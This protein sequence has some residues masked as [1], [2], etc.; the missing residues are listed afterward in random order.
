M[1]STVWKPFCRPLF[2]PRVRNGDDCT[3]APERCQ[4]AVSLLGCVSARRLGL[5]EHGSSVLQPGVVAANKLQEHPLLGHPLTPVPVARRSPVS[6]TGQSSAQENAPASSPTQRHTLILRN[7]LCQMGVIET[8]I[9][10]A[11]QGDYL[12]SCLCFNGV[13]G[14]RRP[15]FPWASAAAPSFRYAACIRQVWRSLKP[16]MAAASRI[17]NCCAT[18]RFNTCNRVCSRWVNVSHERTDIFP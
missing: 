8:R 7:D 14:C 13:A 3:D 12:P 18:N 6:R 2:R 17:V 16:R 1:G 10:R 9:P 11:C 4:H 15:L 5:I